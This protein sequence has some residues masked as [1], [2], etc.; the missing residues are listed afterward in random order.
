MYNVDRCRR[1]IQNNKYGIKDK[2]GPTKFTEPIYDDLRRIEGANE[3]VKVKIQD[4][5][6]VITTTGHLIIKAEFDNITKYD[7]EYFT[8]FRE[9][10]ISRVRNPLIYH[11][12]KVNNTYNIEF[13]SI[14]GYSKYFEGSNTVSMEDC[15][16]R[17]DEY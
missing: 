8:V 15:K 6:G 11:I 13:P 4:K 2:Y 5:W 1:Y 7:G 12:S 17:W 9:D 14:S 10:K 3:Y 16:W